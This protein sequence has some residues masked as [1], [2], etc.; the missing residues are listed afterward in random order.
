[1]KTRIKPSKHSNPDQTIIGVAALLLKTLSK[2][3]VEKYDVLE[4]LVDAKIEGGKYLFLPALNLLYLLGIIKYHK[5]SDAFEY[6]RI[7]K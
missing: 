3:G 4:E 5:K 7:A 6:V 1:M 2:S